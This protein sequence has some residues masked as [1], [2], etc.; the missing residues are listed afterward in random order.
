MP[1]R[2]PLSSSSS[3]SLLPLSDI[4]LTNE[5][6]SISSGYD[7]R[8]ERF[9]WKP[10]VSPCEDTYTATFTTRSKEEETNS[11]SVHSYPEY[12][13]AGYYSVPHKGRTYSKPLNKNSA[14]ATHDTMKSEGRILPIRNDDNVCL[15]PHCLSLTS[16]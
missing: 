11:N 8:I 4:Y 3:F 1:P 13:G 5:K 14:V 9:P 6:E 15:V 16:I 2:P 7:Q 10:I 12:G